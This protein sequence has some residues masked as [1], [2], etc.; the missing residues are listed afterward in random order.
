MSLVVRPI[1]TG[2]SWD[3]AS[4]P[5]YVLESAEL[6]SCFLVCGVIQR[7][8]YNS[9]TRTESVYRPT[10]EAH[11]KIAF[12]RSVRVVCH[13]ARG[14]HEIGAGRT[15]V[16]W[17]RLSAGVTHGRTTRSSR[18]RQR[19]GLLPCVNGL[20]FLP[21]AF[22]SIRTWAAMMGAFSSRSAR[23]SS[24]TWTSCSTFAGMMLRFFSTLSVSASVMFC[25]P[26]IA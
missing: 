14:V 5:D 3:W 11:G 1:G 7:R 8:G 26:S 10:V 9:H 20:H 25:V 6:V 16:E 18:G 24:E 13:P 12:L 21:A 4:C 2:L 19:V 17:Q 15:S 22:L 23:I